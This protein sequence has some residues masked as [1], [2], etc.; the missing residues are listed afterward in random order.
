MRRRNTDDYE[1]RR[2]QII[3]GALKVFSS[4]GFEQAT[5]KE[6]AEAAGIG[7]AGLIYHYFQDKSDLLRQVIEQRVPLLQL[8]THPGRA[9]GAAARGGA[10]PVRPR[11]PEVMENPASMAVM[12]VVI[13]EAMRRPAVAQTVRRDRSQPRVPVPGRIPAAPDGPRRAA[14]RGPGGGGS[15]LRGT[16]LSLPPVT[17]DP[18]DA[19]CPGAEL[20]NSPHHDSGCLSPRDATGPIQVTGNVPEVAPMKH[21][22]PRLLI[23]VLVLVGLGVGGW[24][25]E[26]GRARTRGALSGFFENQPTQVSS[27]IGGRVTQILVKEGDTVRAGQLLVRFETGRPKQRRQPA[28]RRPSRP[29]SS[30]ARSGTDPAPRRSAASEAAVAELSA[31][32]DRLRN[33]P[34]PRRSTRPA[35][36]SARPRRPSGASGP[37]RGPQEIEQ[38]RAAERVARAKLAQAERGPT[39]EER[40]QARARRDAAAAQAVLAARGSGPCRRS[41]PA[42]RDQPAAGRPGASGPANGGGPA[43]R[44]GRGAPPRRGRHARRKSWSRRGRRTS[45]R[46]PPWPWSWPAPAEKTSRPPAPRRRQPGRT[47]ASCERGTRPE[48]IRAAEARRAQ[49]QAAPGCPRGRQPAGADPPGAGRCPRGGGNGAWRPAEPRRAPRPRPRRTASSSAS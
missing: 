33:G 23:P 17:G 5:N 44:D 37:A 48:E 32:L 34:R 28:R 12:R 45:R 43:A 42:R 14:P 47:C 41:P 10:D 18:A 31:T 46:A 26:A 3:D 22:N 6:I 13:G 35:P 8:L 15:L 20:G 19:G 40:A 49:A 1:E 9:D 39:A 25:V 29:A 7:S 4:K 21:P 16:A 36:V 27:R 30:C 2:Q 38:A 11:L 24:Y